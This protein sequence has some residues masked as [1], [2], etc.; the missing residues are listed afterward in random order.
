M[1]SA[2]GAS[3]W[4]LLSQ[5][6]AEGLVLSVAGAVVGTGLAVAG[7]RA[8]LAVNQNA[9][10]RTGEIALDWRVLAFTLVVAVAT[11][12]IFGLVPLLHLR[13]DRAGDAIKD[14]GARTTAGS[15]RARMRALLVVGEIALAVLLVV[16]AGL[17]IRSFYNLTQVDLG[18][19]RSHL[20]TFGV[21]CRRRRTTRRSAW[22][23][24]TG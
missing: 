11:G 13:R 24:S 9:L 18:F 5:L 17:L 16:G 20:T 1:R 22:T 4:R 14:A 15:G 10:P 21:S 6:L 12:V 2:L 3:R 7:V 23:F 8:L 19:K